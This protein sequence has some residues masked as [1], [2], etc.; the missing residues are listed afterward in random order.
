MKACKFPEA[1][2]QYTAA[3]VACAEVGSP[4]YAAVLHSN[5]AA[6]L[7]SQHLHA[8]AMADCLRARALDPGFTKVPPPPP[9]RAALPL[10]LSL[11]Y[12]EG[13]CWLCNHAS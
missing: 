4:V 1:V 13:K 10:P 6:A 3:L 12:I 2:A 11:N 9:P 7:Q 8:E 5:R